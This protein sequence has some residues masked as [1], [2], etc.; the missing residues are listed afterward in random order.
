MQKNWTFGRSAP[1]LS[2]KEPLAKLLVDAFRLKSRFLKSFGIKPHFEAKP[3]NRKENIEPNQCNAKIKNLC[4]VGFFGP[5]LRT[6]SSPDD[7]KTELA[8]R[9]KMEI[10]KKMKTHFYIWCLCQLLN[11]DQRRGHTP[12]HVI[13]GLE[14][15]D[16]ETAQTRKFFQW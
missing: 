3:I 6:T 14:N 10:K 7:G 5:S 9:M 1:S 12:C 8:W 2:F 13:Q 15:C 16:G 4:C 11:V